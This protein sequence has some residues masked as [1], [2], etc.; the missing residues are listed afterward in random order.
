MIR[1]TVG[2]NDQIEAILT[3]EQGRRLAASDIV[4]ARPSPYDSAVWQITPQ[5]KVGVARVGD[6]EVWVTPKLAIDRLLFLVGY[7]ADPKGWRDDLVQLDIRQS[8]IPAVAQALWR[9]VER[10]LHQG[11]MQGYQT[12]EEASPVLRGR[13]R[14]GDQ[15]RRHH[16]RAIPME[17]RHDDYTVDIPENQI[18]LAAI[19][20]LL[21]VPRVDERSRRH[22]AALRIRLAA[23]TSLIKGTTLPHWRPSRLNARY[24]TA[25]RLAEIV[26]RATSP[27]HTPGSVATNGFLFDLTKIFEDF[28]TVAVSEELHAKYGGAAYLQYSCYLDEA[29]AVRMKPDLVWEFGGIPRLVAD[30]KYKQEKPAGYPDADLY[31]MLAYCTALRLSRGHLI[32]AKGNAPAASHLV[33]HAGIEIVCHALDLA[34]PPKAILAQ[35]NGI[36]SEFF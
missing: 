27:E 18:L 21:T 35:V 14:E 31:Q 17:I 23:V 33:R 5:G 7:A 1:L 29:L 19:T 15:L 4:R 11:L 6:V 36:V 13:L 32:Y 20:R 28:V 22:L 12:F 3:Y 16:G 24:H 2:E 10:A 9:Q 8:L 30:A 26:W 25:L 34:S